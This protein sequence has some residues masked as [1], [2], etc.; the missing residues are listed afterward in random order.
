MKVRLRH[1]NGVDLHRMFSAKIL[2][3]SRG[4]HDMPALESFSNEV[5]SCI[6]TSP[7]F[8]VLVE[9]SVNEGKD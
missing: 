6:K 8:T 9:V 3:G 2:G 1:S 5:S 4:F 7:N